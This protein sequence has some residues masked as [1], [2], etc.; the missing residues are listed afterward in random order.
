MIAILA[1]TH[2]ETG[3]GLS[4]AAR[5]A[6]EGADALVHAGDFTAPSV[7]EAFQTA[8]D[9]FEAVHGNRDDPE[10]QDRLPSKRVFEVGGVRI[11]LVH[12]HEHGETALSLL[13]RSEAADLVVFGHSHR[14]T[15][16]E[17]D[18]VPLLNP[19]SHTRPR[20]HR[21]AH[22]ELDDAGRPESVDGAVEAR[23]VATD[24]S[25]ID[26]TRIG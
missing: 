13:G 15:I 18:G 16:I 9:R 14:P 22:A 4:G 2:R 17:G 6:V 3:H 12:G 23:L 19:G 11:V 1:D 26:A 24:G 21:A 25:V 5:E 8:T 10:L 20:G 7:Y